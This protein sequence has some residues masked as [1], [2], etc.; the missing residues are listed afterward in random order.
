MKSTPWEAH[1]VRAGS[2]EHDEDWTPPLVQP[3][4]AAATEQE[5]HRDVVSVESGSDDSS[6]DSDSDDDDAAKNAE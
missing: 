1:E 5:A 4:P 6:S 2:N 3:A